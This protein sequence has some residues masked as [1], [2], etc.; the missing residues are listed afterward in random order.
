MTEVLKQGVSVFTGGFIQGAT[1]FTGG[2]I[3]KYT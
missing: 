2:F 1:V 3:R